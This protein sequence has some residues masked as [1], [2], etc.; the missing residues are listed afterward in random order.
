MSNIY[1]LTVTGTYYMRV[2]A[3]SKEEAW[4][5]RDDHL[6]NDLSESNISEILENTEFEV[7]GIT[8]TGEAA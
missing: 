8:D 1:I 2:A 4:A 5:N 6:S 3:D 7:T